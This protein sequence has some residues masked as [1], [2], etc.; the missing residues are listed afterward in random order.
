MERA[1][2]GHLLIS[3]INEWHGDC[4]FLFVIAGQLGDALCKQIARTSAESPMCQVRAVRKL[5]YNLR[6][7]REMKRELS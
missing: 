4:R 6:E 2:R 3:T 5:K 1:E 7:F